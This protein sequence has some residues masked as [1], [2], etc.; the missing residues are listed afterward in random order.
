[1]EYIPGTVANELRYQ[2]GTPRGQYGTI[3]QDKTFRRQM[4]ALQ[5]KL[6]SLKFDKIGSLYQDPQAEDFTLVPTAIQARAHGTRL[7]N[8]TAILPTKS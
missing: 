1:M 2:I 6:A 4:A 5:V 3:E 7:L 8:T